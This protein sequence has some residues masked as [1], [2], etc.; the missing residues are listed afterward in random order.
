LADAI[1]FNGAHADAVQEWFGQELFELAEADVFN[2]ADYAAA[3]ANEHPRGRSET[4]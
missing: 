1:A 4:I 3:L 2:D